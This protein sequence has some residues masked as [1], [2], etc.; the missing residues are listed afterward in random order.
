MLPFLDG[1][2]CIAVGVSDRSQFLFEIVEELVDLF[3][4]THKKEKTL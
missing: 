3:Q 1:E 2:K 4:H